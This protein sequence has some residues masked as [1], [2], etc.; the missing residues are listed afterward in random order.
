MSG[1]GTRGYTRS[2]GPLRYLC[3]SGHIAVARFRRSGAA[4]Q[5]LATWLWSSALRTTAYDTC[6]SVDKDPLDAFP[7]RNL[8][9]P[10]VV[11]G[12]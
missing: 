1:S 5:E 3:S 6:R 4:R 8:N 11:G 10:L 2:G 7:A 12:N 9:P